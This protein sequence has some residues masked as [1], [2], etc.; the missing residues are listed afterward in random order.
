LRIGLVLGRLLLR[1]DVFGAAGFRRGQLIVVAGD[2]P[3]LRSGHD[4][5]GVES[6]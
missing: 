2:G 4:S 1:G 5:G 3:A 6:F